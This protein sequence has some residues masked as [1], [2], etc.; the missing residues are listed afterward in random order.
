MRNG[1]YAGLYVESVLTDAVPEGIDRHVIH[2]HYVMM[3]RVRAG[4]AVGLRDR[5]ANP[6]TVRCGGR[7]FRHVAEPRSHIPGF[8]LFSA[9]EVG[10]SRSRGDEPSERAVDS[11]VQQCFPARAGMSWP[12]YGGTE[13][14]V[15]VPVFARV[16]PGRDIR[17]RRHH[18]GLRVRSATTRSRGR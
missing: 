16:R 17:N 15:M 10:A 6:R 8:L 13:T 18:S 11:A 4:C 12:G 7:K 9:S 2:G 5:D 14:L 1:Y 3:S